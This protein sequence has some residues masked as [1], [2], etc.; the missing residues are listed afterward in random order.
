VFEPPMRLP[1]EIAELRPLYLRVLRN[2]RVLLILDNA[3]GGDLVAPLPTHEDCALIV[4]SR[5]RIAV[6]GLVGGLTRPWRQRRPVGLLGAIVDDGRA[7][8]RELSRSAELCGLLP[9]TLRIAGMFIE[10]A[11]I[12]AEVHRRPGG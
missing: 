7:T 1:E 8:A 2:E 9:L 4:T 5:R 11:L 3:L 10:P 12:S 6:G